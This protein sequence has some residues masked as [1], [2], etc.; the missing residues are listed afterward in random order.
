MVFVAMVI[1]ITVAAFAAKSRYLNQASP[2]GDDGRMYAL[3][4][5]GSMHTSS[6]TKL[7]FVTAWIDLG[8]DHMEKTPAARLMHFRR[9]AATG[10]SLFVFVSP[11]N[12]AVMEDVQTEFPNILGLRAVDMEDLQTVRIIRSVSNV[13]LPASLTNNKDTRGF[14]EL[15]LAKIDFVYQ[16]LAYTNATH[17]AWIDFNIAHVFDDSLNALEALQELQQRD[18]LTPSLLVFPVIWERTHHLN[19]ETLVQQVNWRFA[20][21]FFLGDRRSLEHWYHLCADTLGLFLV[22]TRKLVWE[23][24]FWAW[25]ENVYPHSFHPAVYTSDHDNSLVAVPVDIDKTMLGR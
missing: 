14:L 13:T 23:V 25:L 18:H 10:I 7:V 11:S 21:G 22:Q 19:L 1:G 17:L 16:A 12:V 24:N 3:T 2:Q 20:G 9:L 5:L 6:P 15:M 8:P 4:P